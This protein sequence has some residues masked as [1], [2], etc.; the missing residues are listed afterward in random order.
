M[1]LV[2]SNPPS[3]DRRGRFLK[4]MR[5]TKGACSV[6]T[7]KKKTGGK[8]T[9]RRSGFVSTSLLQSIAAG[10]AGIAIASVGVNKLPAGTLKTPLQ[11]SLAKA[12]VGVVGGM[13]I[14]KLLKSRAMGLAF[15]TGA[16]ASA[17]IEGYEASTGKSLNGFY[18]P[19][20]VSG[21]LEPAGVSGYLPAP[22]LDDVALL[23]LGCSRPSAVSY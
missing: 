21:F 4:G 2:I 8:K 19:S 20:G 15:A 11:R 6:A 16:G 7:A 10:A 18:E 22:A 9:Y 13:L 1:K 12:A 17:A 23:G 5:K 14:A 3:R